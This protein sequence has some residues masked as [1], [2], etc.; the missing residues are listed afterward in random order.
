MLKSPVLRQQVGWP[1]NMHGEF[2]FWAGTERELR[3]PN[4]FLTEG[5]EAFLKMIAQAATTD[6]T[7]G[8][9]YFIGLMGATFSNDDTLST[10]LGEPSAAGGYAR[11][12]IARSGVGWPTVSKVNGIWRAVTTTVN[13][14]ATAAD[15][16]VPFSR[17]FLCNVV[18]GAVGK[19]FSVSGAL[20]EPKQIVDGETFPIRYE[21][22]LR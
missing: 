2:V 21:L 1:S 6:V 18:S 4:N 22:Y 14:T 5:E 17:A 16:S 13:F 15:F 3:I 7:V 19:L 20:P 10:I 8:G 9:N 11:K 12:P